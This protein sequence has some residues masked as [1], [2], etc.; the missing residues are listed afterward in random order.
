MTRTDEVGLILGICLG[1]N[2]AEGMS[3]TIQSEHHRH[4]Q[5]KVVLRDAR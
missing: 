2:Y 3:T 5:D 4:L 1:Q